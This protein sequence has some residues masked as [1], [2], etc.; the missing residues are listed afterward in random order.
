MD[1]EVEDNKAPVI[2]KSSEEKTNIV[3]F[4]KNKAPEPK[5]FDEKKEEEPLTLTEEPLTLTE[6]VQKR[7]SSI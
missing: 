1:G 3:S 6:E 5:I 2:E 7:L 4:E